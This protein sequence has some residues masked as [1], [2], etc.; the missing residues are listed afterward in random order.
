MSSAR[1]A[2][3]CESRLLG[4][5]QRTSKK[6]RENAEGATATLGESRIIPRISHFLGG[7]V[8]ETIG[9]KCRLSN[10]ASGNRQGKRS[11]HAKK[12]ERAKE[13]L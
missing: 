5:M 4:E 7:I 9:R 6:K 8:W 3:L 13:F 11:R 1:I 2:R 12:E 10:A